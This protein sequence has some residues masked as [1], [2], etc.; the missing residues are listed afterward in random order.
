M[1]TINF[2]K[3]MNPTDVGVNIFSP[4]RGTVLGEYCFENKLIKEID[5]RSFR[6]R[7]Q[8]RLA[9]PTI[10]DER[11][12]SLYK[13]FQFMVYGGTD[14]SKLRVALWYSRFEKIEKLLQDIP[15]V[16]GFLAM[17]LEGLYN[18]FKPL[19]KIMLA[20]PKGIA[21]GNDAK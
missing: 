12:T 3:R 2:N 14:P 17:S 4:Y 5:P 16:G 7:R 19:A 20:R 21:A 15:L 11:L 1:E 6:D 13:N 18:L 9:L 10:S 8:S